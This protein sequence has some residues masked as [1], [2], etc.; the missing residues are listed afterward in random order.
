[1]RCASKLADF[2]WSVHDPD[3]RRLTLCGTPDYMPPEMTVPGGSH[4]PNVDVWALGVL[5]FEFLCGTSP[6]ESSDKKKLIDNIRNVRIVF[7]GNVSQCARDFI[8]RLLHKDPKQRL[9][10]SQVPEH[11][12]IRKYKQSW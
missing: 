5:S 6:F 3:L 1:M 7:P 11:P 8:K 4:D 9:P 2:G 12:F 10:L